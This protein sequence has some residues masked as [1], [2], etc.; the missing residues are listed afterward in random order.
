MWARILVLALLLASASAIGS[1]ASP[2]DGGDSTAHVD[3]IHISAGPSHYTTIEPG[4]PAID[5]SQGSA[6][7]IAP[8]TILVIGDGDDPVRDHAFSLVN[9]GDEARQVAVRY[10]YEQTPP[11]PA[12][13]S[14]EVVGRDGTPLSSSSDGPVFRLAPDQRVYLIVVVDTRGTTVHDD[15]SGSLE[16]VVS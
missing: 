16:F 9:T 7:G 3:T 6:K 10:T 13:V 11:E 2:I 15:L 8:N 14:F 1:A 4:R 12:G 5:F